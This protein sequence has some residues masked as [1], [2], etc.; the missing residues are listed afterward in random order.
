MFS[1][2]ELIKQI[3]EMHRALDGRILDTTVTPNVWRPATTESNAAAISAV[4]DIAEAG[5]DLLTFP[6]SLG[7]YGNVTRA[8]A[9]TLVDRV[10]AALRSYVLA[11][12]KAA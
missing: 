9:N 10:S 3:I 7:A 1:L 6:L 2:A 5:L 4:N 12:T 11:T 8:Q